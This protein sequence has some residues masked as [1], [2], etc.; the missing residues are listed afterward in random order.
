[1]EMART[2]STRRP[3][4]PPPMMLTWASHTLTLLQQ[5]PMPQR[6][7]QRRRLT[8]RRHTNMRRIRSRAHR[9]SNPVNRWSLSARRARLEPDEVLAR[10]QVKLKSSW[11]V[12]IEVRRTRRSSQ[13][14]W[15]KHNWIESKCNCQSLISLK[16]AVVAVAA[17]RW[18]VSQNQEKQE[19]S[20]CNMKMWKLIS[21]TFDKWRAFISNLSKMCA[22]TSIQLS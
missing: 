9:W 14:S 7:L 17:L 6:Q 5:Q 21:Y 12:S 22:F 11:K 3:V 20:K 13:C 1:M 19:L 8:R 4:S 15:V 10:K 18:N 2:R 16:S